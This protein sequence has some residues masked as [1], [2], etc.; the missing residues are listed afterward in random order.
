VHPFHK[1]RYREKLARLP[2]WDI[3]PE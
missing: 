1:R 3:E 2:R